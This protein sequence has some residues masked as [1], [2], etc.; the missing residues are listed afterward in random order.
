MEI[1]AVLAD[2]KIKARFVALGNTPLPGSATDFGK[3]MADE[4]EKWGK[5]VKFANIKV[6]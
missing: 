1:N 3:Q 4:A 6:E 2:P 5:A